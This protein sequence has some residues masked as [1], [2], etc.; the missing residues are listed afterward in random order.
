MRISRRLLLAILAVGLAACGGPRSGEAPLVVFAAASLRDVA[1][2]VAVEFER[3]NVPLA[4]LREDPVD[5]VY[6]F[7]GSTTLAQQIR[8]APGADVFLSADERWVDDLDQAGRTVP[9]SRRSFLSNRL[10]VIA[11][12]D[13]DFEIDDP[14]DL[15]SLEFR[16]LALADPDAVPAGRYARAALEHVS[17]EGGDLWTRVAGRLAPALD[18]RAA[19]ALVESDLE[20]LG[21]V[22][23][24]DAMTSEK[25]KVLHELPPLDDAP[26][27]Y[28]AVLVADG[29]NPELGRRYLDFL[30]SPTAREIAERRGFSAAK[31]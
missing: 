24:T 7:A 13:A 22:Y 3:R 6:N 28:S 31:R 18:V 2:D 1:A 30:T 20:I 5:V 9:G 8:A 14:R 26:I 23:R 27:L 10:V 12:R 29:D 21:I 17:W 11:H 16:F 25:V 4:S 15:D 19:L